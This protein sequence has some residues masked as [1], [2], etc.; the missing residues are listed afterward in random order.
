MIGMQKM[1]LS[2]ITRSNRYTHSLNQPYPH[3]RINKSKFKWAIFNEN[4]LSC[5]IQIQ[6]NIK[7][8]VISDLL[9]VVLSS[10]A[11]LYHSLSP[12]TSDSILSYHPF[13]RDTIKSLQWNNTMLQ[14]LHTHDRDT[15]KHQLSFDI[16]QIL[17]LFIMFAHKCVCVLIF[18]VSI[19]AC[20]VEFHH[21]YLNI[22]P[23]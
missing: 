19:Y 11:L 21:T 14:S 13:Q 3:K 22:F 8:N 16:Q 17:L 10:I 9:F 2:L 15:Q 1:C 23:H 18:N 4:A 7:F 6:H 5:I 12:Y 20:H